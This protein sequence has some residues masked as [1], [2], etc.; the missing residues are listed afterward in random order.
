MKYLFTI[1]SLLFSLGISNAQTKSYPRN[2]FKIIP[3]ATFD[4]YYTAYD[5]SYGICYERFIDRDQ[6]CSWNVPVYLG[7]GNFG[8]ASYGSEL[9]F[10]DMLKINPGIKFY[11]FGQK[12]LTYGI[13]LS[14][15]YVTG[16]VIETYYGYSY[17]DHYRLN[18]FG[19]MLQ[20]SLSY[21]VSKRINLNLEIGYGPSI[22]NQ[23]KN[24]KQSSDHYNEQILSM[25]HAHLC[26]GYRF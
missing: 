15:F 24:T 1:L 19:L 13:G 16:K 21:N 8:G 14:L 2:N 5:Y 9:A 17:P 22:Y 25:R 7:R 20:N 3:V 23:Y 18:Q 26:I 11:P 6:K 12:R 10:K 4:L